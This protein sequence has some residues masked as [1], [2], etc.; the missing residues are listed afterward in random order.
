MKAIPEYKWHNNQEVALPRNVLQYIPT[1]LAYENIDRQDKML[2]KRDIHSLVWMRQLC[3]QWV[4]AETSR[5]KTQ[6]Q[7]EK[8][9]SITPSPFLLPDYNAG[10]R[11][12]PDTITPVPADTREWREVRTSQ[13][14]R[15]AMIASAAT[16]HFSSGNVCSSYPKIS[17]PVPKFSTH[18]RGWRYSRRSKCYV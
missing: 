1:V 12:G 3:C 4:A 11:C 15:A 8:K 6:I 18:P 5:R 2:V 16:Y 13:E 10:Q 14:A 17:N 7:K 9:R